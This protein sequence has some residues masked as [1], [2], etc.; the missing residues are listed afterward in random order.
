M[1]YGIY[2]IAQAKGY[3]PAAAWLMAAGFRVWGWL[4]HRMVTSFVL[5][6]FKR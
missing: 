2:S 4:G 5:A 1:L 6:L 3:G